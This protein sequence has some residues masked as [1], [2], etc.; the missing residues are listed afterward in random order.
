MKKF[1]GTLVEGKFA[2]NLQKEIEG[3]MSTCFSVIIQDILIHKVHYGYHTASPLSSSTT[4]RHV[5][6]FVL[7]GFCKGDTVN[8]IHPRVYLWRKLFGN[9]HCVPVEPPL[10][11]SHAVLTD[12]EFISREDLYPSYIMTYVY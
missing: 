4:S 1:L 9:G 11:L 12:T 5:Q 2:K 3:M 7:I 8:K 10:P 6:H